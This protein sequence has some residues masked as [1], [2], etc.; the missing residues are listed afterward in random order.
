MPTILLTRP[1]IETNEQQHTKRDTIT[2]AEL[3]KCSVYYITVSYAV[4]ILSLTVHSKVISDNNKKQTKSFLPK[5]CHHLWT[6][7]SIDQ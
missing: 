5:Q 3:C 6:G 2:D 4:L 1:L 7:L